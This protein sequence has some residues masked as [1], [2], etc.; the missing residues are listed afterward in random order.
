MYLNLPLLWWKSDASLQKIIDK[1]GMKL[2][3]EVLQNN[4]SVILLAPHSL[5]LEF[6]G[7][8]ISGYDVLSMYKP[9]KNKLI[10]WFTGGLNHQVEHHIFPN[11]SHI[12]YGKIAE[13]VKKTAKEFNL[14]YNEYK[15]TRKA[16]IAHF[17]YLRLMGMKP[18]LQA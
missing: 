10:N 5:S 4:Q 2:V 9:F 13:I 17:N 18:K 1:E 8:A 3:D 6:G 14:P 7:R 12:H 11:I 16:I 15:T